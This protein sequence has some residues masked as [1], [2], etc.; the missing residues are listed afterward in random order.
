M[1][2]IFADT[3]NLEHEFDYFEER[4]IT[5]KN[6]YNRA[7]LNKKKDEL[8]GHLKIQHAYWKQ[9]A[10]LQWAK[11]VDM[12]TSFFHKSVTTIRRILA[13]QKI[14]NEDEQWIEEEDQIANEA[15]KCFENLFKQPQQQADLSNFECL[16]NI[17]TNQDNTELTRMPTKEEIKETVF[18]MNPD[19]APGLDG[20]TTLFF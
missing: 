1:G 19:F 5:S 6:E 4:S 7:I 11:D 2:D 13:I 14:K 9:K 10:N 12:N 18:S 16:E 17:I 8:T 3:K 15:I 20:F